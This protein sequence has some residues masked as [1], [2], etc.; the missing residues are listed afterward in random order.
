MCGGR[1]REASFE[2]T[3][4][5]GPRF[6]RTATRH[7]RKRDKGDPVL[8]KCSFNQQFTTSHRLPHLLS[9]HPGAVTMEYMS[10]IAL[11]H[12]NKH[13]TP[14]EGEQLGKIC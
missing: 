1:L 2:P 8:D 13:H 5:P 6:L 4:Q 10:G 12:S 11:Y 3:R 7:S 14:A 9:P